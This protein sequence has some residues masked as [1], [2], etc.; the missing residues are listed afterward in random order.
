MSGRTCNPERPATIGLI[1]LGLIGSAVSER[2][3]AAGHTVIGFD[4]VEEF[5]NKL[6]QIGGVRTGTVQ[7][8]AQATDIV[9]LALPN[10]VATAEVLG[11]ISTS[12]RPGHILADL[13][14]GDPRAAESLAA[15]LHERGVQF[16]DA[17]ISGSSAQVRRGDVLVMVGGEQSAF[18]VTQRLFESFAWQVRHVG[19]SG[20]G[21]WMKLVTN[22][23]L[24]LNRAALAEGLAFAE[25]VGVDP[26]DALAVLRD[27]MAY[28]RI[29]D[30]KGPKMVSHNFTPE[31]RLSQH[32]KDLRLIREAAERVGQSL[33]LSGEHQRLLELA[34]SLGLGG[35]DNSAIIEALRA[36]P[37]PNSSHV[38]KPFV[39]SFHSSGFFGPAE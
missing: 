39:V 38:L 28:S 30:T 16:L 13:G 25:S 31:A 18:D 12:L 24:G 34:E 4:V 19:P 14:T 23:V 11:E 17:T 3:L 32:L 1:G 20:Q 15:E 26:A 9:M 22:L 8:V 29:M 27:S 5:R 2:L 33:P 7:E 36:R 21:A 10:D 37:I 35:L 6:S